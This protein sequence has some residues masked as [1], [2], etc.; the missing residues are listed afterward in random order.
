MAV[1]DDGWKNASDLLS[2]QLVTSESDGQ[3]PLEP[4]CGGSIGLQCGT[5]DDDDERQDCLVAIVKKLEPDIDH[6]RTVYEFLS[7]SDLPFQIM[8]IH[9]W[10]TCCHPL[11]QNEAKKDDGCVIL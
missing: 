7:I 1:W 2:Q 9:M 8:Q 5:Y 4:L 6:V 11:L 3:S 10:V